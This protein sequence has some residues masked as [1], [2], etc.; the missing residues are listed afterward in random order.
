[1][2]FI[3]G[4][5][6]EKLLEKKVISPLVGVM[7]L[8]EICQ[9][10]KYAHQQGIVH[11]DL[12]P[13]NIMIN[14][15]GVVK[16]TDFGISHFMGTRSILTQPDQIIGTPLY[17]APE[18]VVGGKIDQRSD[19]FALGVVLYQILTGTTPF[20][21]ETTAAITQKILNEKYLSPLEI[22]PGLPQI[23]VLITAKCLLKKPER[24]YQQVEEVLK[25]FDAF[26]RKREVV[27]TR[28]ELEKYIANPE[29]Y[30]QERSSFKPKTESLKVERKTKKTFWPVGVGVVVV[31]FLLF[32]GKIFLELK[33]V[34]PAFKLQPEVEKTELEISEKN[35]LPK[36]TQVLEKSSAKKAFLQKKMAQNKPTIKESKKLEK[37]PRKADL[38]QVGP[39]P[40][41]ESRGTE[42]PE[43]IEKPAG[44]KK[45]VRVYFGSKPIAQVFINGKEIGKTPLFT[46]LPPGEYLVKLKSPIT[47]QHEEKIVIPAGK[48]SYHQ[49]L[50]QLKLLPA[51][52][53][54]NPQKY[55]QVIIEGKVFKVPANGLVE[56]P[57]GKEGVKYKKTFPYQVKC[58]NHQP[59]IREIKLVPGK[60]SAWE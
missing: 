2:E 42:G 41:S 10:L 53:K 48:E 29:R 58:I 23:L 9:G 49:P 31:F 52:L 6:L 3:E 27:D 12:K 1:M 18:Q 38:A 22:K 16:L 47:F 28:A 25:D 5:N 7:V 43:I 37:S 8:K 36:P 17:M 57:F 13:A 15:N 45:P 24:R 50:F 60:I 14:Q 33:Q 39:G 19:I 59:K 40:P 26:L 4:T 46:S 34:K 11:R 55:H 30:L 51:Y 32:L 21:A 54:I 35:P 20:Y 44:I 56:I